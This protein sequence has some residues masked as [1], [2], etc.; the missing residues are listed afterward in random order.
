[1][2]FTNLFL[3]KLHPRTNFPE[4][5]IFHANSSG[6]ATIRLPKL[7]SW[8]TSADNQ[9][10]MGRYFHD[11]LYTAKIWKSPEVQRQVPCTSVLEKRKETSRNAKVPFSTNTNTR[12]QPRHFPHW[13][14]QNGASICQHPLFGIS[15]NHRIFARRN[16]FGRKDEKTTQTDVHWSALKK[17]YGARVRFWWWSSIA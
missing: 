10:Q 11:A 15:R 2:I 5:Y 8:Q 12:H 4:I 17:V 1:M 9:P 6:P 16:L 13:K 7:F 3:S 14:A